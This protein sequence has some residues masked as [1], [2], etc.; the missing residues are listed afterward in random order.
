MITLL[1]TVIL[2][3]CDNETKDPPSAAPSTVISTVTP[4]IERPTLYKPIYANEMLTLP[5][6]GHS[7]GC[8]QSV[9]M[10]IDNRNVK[11]SRGLWDLPQWDLTYVTCEGIT[12]KHSTM[13]MPAGTPS[14]EECAEAVEANPLPNPI[15][16]ADIRDRMPLER[17]MNLCL[18]TDA[19]RISVL[20]VTRVTGAKGSL[21][22]YRFLAT[23]WERT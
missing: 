23:L 22:T 7:S 6:A 13:G 14:P 11:S 10:D 16:D 8:W 2:V 5:A 9:N 1:G 12:A 17:G 18:R 4:S 19:G 3:T 21:K 15:T 20:A